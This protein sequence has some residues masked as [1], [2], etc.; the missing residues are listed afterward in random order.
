[1]TVLFLFTGTS[2]SEDEEEDVGV[3]WSRLCELL[4]DDELVEE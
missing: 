3:Y 4:D 1:M 2:M